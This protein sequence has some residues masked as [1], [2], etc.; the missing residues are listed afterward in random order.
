MARTH[1]RVDVAAVVVVMALFDSL[2]CYFPAEMTKTKTT[3]PPLPPPTHK[4]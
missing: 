3:E 2:G 1:A 4:T